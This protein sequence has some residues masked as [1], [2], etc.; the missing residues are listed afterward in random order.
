[1]GLSQ[2]QQV[3]HDPTDETPPS[4]N[5]IANSRGARAKNKRAQVHRD[6]LRLDAQLTI[7]RR[8]ILDR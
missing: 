5:S 3:A 2:R 1:M 6:A 7:K 4:A 8:K